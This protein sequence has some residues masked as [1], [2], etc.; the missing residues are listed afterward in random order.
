MADL[1]SN[2]VFIEAVT[3]ISINQ[4]MM[5]RIIPQTG[6]V[7]MLLAANPFVLGLFATAVQ[8]GVAAAIA[9]G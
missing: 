5:D 2:S 4:C 6:E 9:Q 8:T 1:I 7:M 3:A